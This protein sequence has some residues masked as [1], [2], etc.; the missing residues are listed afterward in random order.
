MDRPSNLGELRRDRS[1]N[2]RAIGDREPHVGIDEFAVMVQDRAPEL[3]DKYL[4]SESVRVIDQ[5]SALPFIP[6]IPRPFVSA[7]LQAVLDVDILSIL[8]AFEEN[9]IIDPIL[10]IG[11]AHV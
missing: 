4:R 11:R 6:A 5:P 3:T 9:M 10:K 2:H 7:L 8:F 1:C